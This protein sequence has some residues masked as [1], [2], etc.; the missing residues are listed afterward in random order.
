MVSATSLGTVRRCG[1]FFPLC[2]I[3]AGPSVVTGRGASF[4]PRIG[5]VHRVVKPSGVLYI[6]ALRAATR[7]VITSTITLGRTVNNG[8]CVGIPVNRTNLGTAPVVGSGNVNI[9]VATVF[10]P[11]RTLLSTITNT[12]FMTPCIG[13]LSGVDNSNYNIITRVI[14]LFS[15]F[16]LSYRILT[17]SFGGISRMGHYTVYNY[18][19][20]AVTPRVF[21]TLVTRPVASTNVTNFR[22]S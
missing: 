4:L 10:A 3:A 8:F 11:T 14:R 13:H 22:G 19:D 20:M 5:G 18:R 16:N 1:R 2:N 12:S 21:S 17:T 6:R 15:G 7:N 9:L